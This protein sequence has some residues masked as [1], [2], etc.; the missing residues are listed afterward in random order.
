[1]CIR[2]SVCTRF[3]PLL[4]PTSPYPFYE[5]PSGEEHKHH[6]AQQQG[7]GLQAIVL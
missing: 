1:M 6:H 5:K 2:L 3:A 4:P 7:L